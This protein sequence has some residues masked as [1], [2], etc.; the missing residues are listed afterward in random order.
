MASCP[1]CD[2][3]IEGDELDEFDVDLGDR[4]SCSTCGAGL[5]VVNLSPV[6]LAAEPDRGPVGLGDDAEENLDDGDG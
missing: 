6:E 5:E 4:L 2:A 3:E 1:V